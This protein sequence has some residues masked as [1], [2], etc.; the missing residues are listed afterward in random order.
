MQGHFATGS[1]LLDC[2]G[3]GGLQAGKT[4]GKLVLSVSQ[5]H[6]CLEGADEPTTML[7]QPEEC[8]VLMVMILSL[9]HSA[10][11]AMA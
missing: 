11:L 10:A 8:C 2:K 1:F 9:P 4:A 7:Q 6:E 5:R 3:K